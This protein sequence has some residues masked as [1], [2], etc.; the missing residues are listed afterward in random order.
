MTARPFTGLSVLVTG[1]IAGHTRETVNQT[2]VRLGGKAVASV[3]A[4]TGLVIVGEGAGVSKMAK[5]R[6]H[7]LDVIGPDTFL[8]LAAGDWDGRTVGE[9]VAQW[10]A[11]HD[12]EPEEEPD[13]A[14]LVPLSERHL[15]TKI[16]LHAP[17]NGDPGS[18]TEREVR[19]RCQCG[20]RW[21]GAHI[22]TH[23]VCPVEAGDAT[24]STAAP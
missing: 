6:T 12:P 1:D 23:M 24:L 7:R 16:V 17:P 13:P 15:V 2:I 5:T 14:D 3:S 19:M 11:R 22:H 18:R 20:H 21:L 4:K 10:E 9:P 8:A